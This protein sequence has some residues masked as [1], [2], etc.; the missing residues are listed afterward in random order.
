MQIRR[1]DSPI[2]RVMS[3][4]SRTAYSRL[5]T[6]TPSTTALTPSTRF[7][8]RKSSMACSV[9]RRSSS[10]T[11]SRSNSPSTAVA[12]PS[13][14]MKR[15]R[16]TRLDSVRWRRSATSSCVCGI[17]SSRGLTSSIPGEPLS[18]GMV[19]RLRTDAM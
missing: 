15:L 4:C 7:S 14:L 9:G 16:K 19:E 6:G 5:T 13:G 12:V 10:S 17:S 1:I 18:S 8:C 3:C 2:A 11:T